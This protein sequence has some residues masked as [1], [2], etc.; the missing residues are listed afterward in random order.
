MFLLKCELRALLEY[1]GLE[2]HQT[3][4]EL[5]AW[6]EPLHDML[7]NGAQVASHLVSVHMENCQLGADIEGVRELPED[8]GEAQAHNLGDRA[9]PR[10]RF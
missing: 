10:W 6:I 2:I 3:V 7:L 5:Q 1:A 4:E 8:T 9:G